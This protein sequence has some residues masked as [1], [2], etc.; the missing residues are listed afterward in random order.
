[1][2]A[3]A[4]AESAD[5]IKTVLSSSPTTDVSKLR[6]KTFRPSLM[7]PNKVRGRHDTQHNDTPH[8][9][10]RHKNKLN[11]ILSIFN[12]SVVNCY[13]ECRKPTHFDECC[14]AECR[15]AECRYAEC[16]YAECRYS[17]CHY[18]EC[19]YAECHYTECRYAE[20]HLL[21]VIMLSVIMLNAFMPSAFMLSAI[22]LNVV[23]LSAVAP[24]RAYPSGATFFTSL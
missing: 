9:D 4:T 12:G 24:V 6:R 13:A 11:D 5:L 16:H 21:N 22:M 10:I 1:M 18:A 17:E 2:E 3:A 7:L 15:Y 8:N 20:C 23:M 14:Y 19:L